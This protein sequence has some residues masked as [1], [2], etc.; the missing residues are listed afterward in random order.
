M[1]AN[2][3]VSI[4]QSL[5]P[6][7]ISKIASMLGLDPN[8]VQ[9]GISAIV[10]SILASFANLA[11][12]PDGGRQLANA[13]SQQP[14]DGANLL[15]SA[16]GDPSQM[17]KF[18]DSGAG[19]LSS[20]L[21]GGGLSALTSAVSR[22][23]GMSPDAGKSLVGL[24]APVVMSG[25]GQQQR[26]ANLDSGALASLLNSQKD[27]IS[28]AMPSGLADMLGSTGLLGPVSRLKDASTSAA[29]DA[30]QASYS[31][32]RR[33]S[34][35]NWL[36]WAAGLA[37][38]LGAGWYFLGNPGDQKVA[39]QEPSSTAQSTQTVGNAAA[40]SAT[41]L[42]QQLTSSVNTVKTALQGINDSASAQAAL[43]KLQ[44]ATTQL[45]KVDQLRARLP[46]AAN[47]ELASTVA[48]SMP[49]LNQLCDKVLSTPGA[50]NVAKSTINALRGK[51]D[52]LSRA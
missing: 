35:P 46:A 9:K 22:F 25:V 41:D 11:S 16:L 43:P 13:L 15:K 21:G 2:L 6:E 49:V 27:Q 45:E 44:Q 30:A 47:Q 29:N 40:V 33:A 34:S 31:T 17:T 18:S 12:N 28:A 52:A 32:A 50:A 20:L 1:A 14:P 39:E 23:A 5:S 38:L 48:A 24:V 3:V 10:P 4:M 36:Y 42:T 19:M 26:G 7:I 51:L 8:I 37:V